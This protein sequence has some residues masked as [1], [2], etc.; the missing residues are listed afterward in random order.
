M[1]MSMFKRVILIIND[2]IIFYKNLKKLIYQDN[3]L[4]S[5]KMNF[6]FISNLNAFIYI[7]LYDCMLLGF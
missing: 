7:K 5:H 2:L 3:N 6:L 4:L 1:I